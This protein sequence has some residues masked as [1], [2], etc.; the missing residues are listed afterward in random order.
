MSLWGSK[1]WLHKGKDAKLY[2]AGEMLV[3]LLASGFHES[4]C[5]HPIFTRGGHGDKQAPPALFSL[6]GSVSQGSLGDKQLGTPFPRSWGVLFQ[7]L[8]TAKFISTSQV[9]FL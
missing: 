4:A 5:P 3:G 9:L 6:S 7:G 2:E 8:R 1:S